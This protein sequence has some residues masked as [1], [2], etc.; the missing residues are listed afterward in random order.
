M[1]LT[2]LLAILPPVI[3]SI[4]L[5]HAIRDDLC[6]LENRAVNAALS[7]HSPIGDEEAYSD[8]APQIISDSMPASNYKAVLNLD[9]RCGPESGSCG[10]DLCCSPTGKIMQDTPFYYLQTEF[11]QDIVAIHRIIVVHQ[12]VKS[13]MVFVMVARHHKVT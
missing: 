2:H 5:S 12:I 4:L 9:P 3:A 1:Y 7:L 10:Q 8:S 11:H 13:I 6:S